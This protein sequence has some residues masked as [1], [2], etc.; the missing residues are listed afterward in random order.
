M[1]GS[2]SAS[3]YS[4]KDLSGA[5]DSVIGPFAFSGKIGAGQIS[6]DMDTEKTAVDTAA[7]GAIM[8]SH[9]AGDSGS[10]QIEVQQTSI[11]HKFL[12]R[13]YNTLKTAADAGDDSNWASTGLSLRNVTDGTSHVLTGICFSK[14][15][16][17]VYTA[18]GQ[19]LTWKLIA[20]DVQNLT[21]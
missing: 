18:Q 4:F 8:L 21:S 9:M 7:D 6:I 15:P 12:L 10:I 3:V 19:K 14:I 11:F 5:L 2:S 20:A 17:K 1:A 13:L 16:T